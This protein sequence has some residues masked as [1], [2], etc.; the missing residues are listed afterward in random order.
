MHSPISW[1][2]A[3]TLGVMTTSPWRVLQSSDGKKK[4]A[5]KLRGKKHAVPATRPRTAVNQEFWILASPPRDPPTKKQVT[6]A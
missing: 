1:D 3:M 2:G 6:P 4:A 5:R